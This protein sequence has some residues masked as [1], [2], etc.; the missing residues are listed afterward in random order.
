MNQE[1]VSTFSN[2]C[3]FSHCQI[4]NIL[5]RIS[6]FYIKESGQLLPST[7]D[8][9]AGTKGCHAR[10][11][12]VHLVFFI[13]FLYFKVYSQCKV[14]LLYNC[15]QNAENDWKMQKITKEKFYSEWFCMF[16]IASAIDYY[17]LAALKPCR[18]IILQFCR[19][20]VSQ[21]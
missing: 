18:F 15:F 8:Q 3:F 6:Y 4:L 12:L 9:K 16:P 14:Y 13:A 19:S 5:V 17:T 1:T 21:G 11:I 10:F 20:E 7:R 2:F